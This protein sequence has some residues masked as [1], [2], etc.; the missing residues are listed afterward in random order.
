[1]QINNSETSKAGLKFELSDTPYTSDLRA[2]H[3][4]IGQLERQAKRDAVRIDE[5]EH[6][7]R[8]TLPITYRAA[9]LSG[10]ILLPPLCTLSAIFAVLKMKAF[11]GP[12]LAFT[13]SAGLCWFVF[14]LVAS[15]KN[16]FSDS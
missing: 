5:L 10:L 7:D 8:P 6:P 12:L 4:R 16:W 2:A 3:A 15:D 13:L 11:A 1:M 9:L 14:I